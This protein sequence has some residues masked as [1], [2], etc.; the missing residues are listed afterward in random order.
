[1]V[2]ILDGFIIVTK[3]LRC[4]DPVHRSNW[5]H[6]VKLENLI[7]QK[8][9]YSWVFHYQHPKNVRIEVNDQPSLLPRVT[10]KHWELTKLIPFWIPLFLWF[11]RCSFQTE[12]SSLCY[13]YLCILNDSLWW[14]LF[15]NITFSCFCSC[16]MLTDEVWMKVVEYISFFQEIS[17]E[18]LVQAIL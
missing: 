8:L 13:H 7:F 15:L 16:Q 6:G 18:F 14:Y 12:E 4:R 17:D 1:M 11:C 2:I 10:E 3:W 9:F 5:D